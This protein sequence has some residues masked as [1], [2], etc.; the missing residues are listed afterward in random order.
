MRQQS[1][2]DAASFREAGVLSA[3]GAA[4]LALAWGGAGHFQSVRGNLPGAI[5]PG[6]S[7]VHSLSG[8]VR[9]AATSQEDENGAQRCHVPARWT[10]PETRAMK[11]NAS[12]RCRV[13]EKMVYSER[14]GGNPWRESQLGKGLLRKRASQHL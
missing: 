13:S 4:L 14:P 7:Q 5:A 3:C 11:V 9:I 8:Q 1:S 12:E 6:A 10:A 2:D